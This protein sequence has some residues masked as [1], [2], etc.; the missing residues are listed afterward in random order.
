MADGSYT[1]VDNLGAMTAARNYNRFL[2]QEVLRDCR[3]ASAVVDFGA[4]AARFC[5]NLEN[6]G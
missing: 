3:G 4:A 6:A 1:G 5:A 2:V